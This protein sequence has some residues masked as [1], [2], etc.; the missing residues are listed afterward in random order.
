MIKKGPDGMEDTGKQI[1][2]DQLTRAHMN[3]QT[4]AASPGPTE[5]CT[6]CSMYILWRLN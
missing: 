2:L 6:R 1:P 5:V 3:S 4:E